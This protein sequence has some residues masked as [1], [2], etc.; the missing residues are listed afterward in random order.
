MVLVLDQMLG[1]ARTE[2]ISAF[3]ALWKHVLRSPDARGN[4]SLRNDRSFS[5]GE[6]KLMRRRIRIS[7]SCGVMDS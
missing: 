5:A 4:R 7:R 2:R 1:D 6:F 3:V